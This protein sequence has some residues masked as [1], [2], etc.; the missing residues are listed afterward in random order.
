MRKSKEMLISTA[1]VVVCAATAIGAD[2]RTPV[3][4]AIEK[5][6]P[7]V[8]NISAERI[9]RRR[10]DPL[11]GFRDKMFDELSRN[12]RD[13]FH[14]HEYRKT[15]LGS[16]V[17]VDPSGIVVTN[18]HV[19]SRSS[20]ISVTL[21]DKRRY[22]GKLISSDPK[23][24]LAV[25][26]IYAPG[27]LPCIKLGTSSDLMIGETVIAMGNPFGL[28]NSV[29]VGVLSATD[30]AVRAEGRVVLEHLIQLDAAIN[31]GNSG[32]AL[33]N[34]NGELIGINTAIVAEAEGIGFALPVDR[35]RNVLVGLLDY[36][37]LQGVWLGVRLQEI[38]PDIAKN[39]NVA[40]RGA[41]VTDVEPN[42]PASSKLRRTDTILAADGRPVNHP[43][44]FALSMLNKKAGD[45]L[46]IKY[47]R[48]GRELTTTLRVKKMPQE[49]GLDLARKK[50]GL[51]LQ[52]LSR[53]IARK[54]D[55]DPKIGLLVTGVEKG[56]PAFDAGLERGDVI[57]RLAGMPIAEADRFAALLQ[58]LRHGAR[59]QVL[60]YRRNA[61]YRGVIKVR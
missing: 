17:I 12:F 49:S 50:L 47:A 52:K 58:H 48:D 43:F 35:V 20:K 4:E 15:S 59:V 6:S 34:I 9:I 21:P 53:D 2:R 26:K 16:G 41:L 13:R 30:R 38:T 27:P 14:P 1:L 25:L 11:F 46:R 28:Q 37:L 36:R 51:E 29:S 61:L 60:L 23:N 56:S 42:S 8:V 40:L 55:V 33:V 44:D 24:D 7:A 57:L 3:V 32:G 5:C 22:S 18:E 39:L 45:A 31:P 19:I 10:Y 54:L